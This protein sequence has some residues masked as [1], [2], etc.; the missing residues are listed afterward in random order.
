MKHI[1]HWQQH[2]MLSPP[3]MHRSFYTDLINILALHESHTLIQQ[4][5]FI[6]ATKKSSGR[7]TNDGARLSMSMKWNEEK[8]A[9]SPHSHLWYFLY[10]LSVSFLVIL[11]TR[12]K[13]PFVSRA[14]D[15]TGPSLIP[16]TWFM[17]HLNW[18]CS[19]CHCDY[20]WRIIVP[21][22]LTHH[23]VRTPVKIVPQFLSLQCCRRDHK[24]QAWAASLNLMQC[25]GYGQSVRMQGILLGIRG[26]GMYIECI[27]Y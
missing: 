17:I 19:S 16:N 25:N 22:L 12:S 2:S 5:P 11:H 7:Y 20:S 26:C 23:P 13:V 14:A 18:I 9:S 1:A 27:I 10:W 4:F 15:P 6:H 24:P 3:S 21:H 8:H